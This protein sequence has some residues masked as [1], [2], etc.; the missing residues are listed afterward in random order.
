VRSKN[1][2]SPV[3]DA[4]L[5]KYLAGYPQDAV[6]ALHHRLMKERSGLRDKFNTGSLYLG[7]AEGKSD[8]LYVYVKKKYLVFDVRAP[9]EE[10]AV[11]MKRQGFEIQP[12]S[13]WQASAGWLTGLR[14]PHDVKKL[15]PIVKLALYALEKHRLCQ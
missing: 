7:Y 3:T 2:I 15:A 1:L 10:Y 4:V 6:S 8:A 14:V 9:A 13:N 11:E 12:K 5:R